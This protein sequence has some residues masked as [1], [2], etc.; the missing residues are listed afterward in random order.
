LGQIA[1]VWRESE[2]Q[3]VC[4]ERVSEYINNERE[5]EWNTIDESRNWP[6]SGAGHLQF[7]DVC[8]RYRNE[9]DL[10]LNNVS[11]DVRAGEKVGIVGRTGAG[12]MN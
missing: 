1:R 11:F 4:I 12:K 5:P 10:V 9:L 3:M 8:L 6:P 7:K 2:V